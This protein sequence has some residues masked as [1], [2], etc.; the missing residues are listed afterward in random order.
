MNP[1]LLHSGW[2]FGGQALLD[3]RQAKENP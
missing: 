3:G 1:L 2:S